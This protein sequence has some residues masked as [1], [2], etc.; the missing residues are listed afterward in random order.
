MSIS[1]ILISLKNIN[2]ECLLEFRIRSL[3]ENDFNVF[4][5]NS[6][7]I[8]MSL[9]IGSKARASFVIVNKYY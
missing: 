1:S 9:S 3:M 4:N 2:K 5:K 6:F 8:F 7:S